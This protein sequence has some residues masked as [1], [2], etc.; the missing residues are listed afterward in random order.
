MEVSGAAQAA[1][2]IST[3]SGEDGDF[4]CC[5][6]EGI[7]NVG[8]QVSSRIFHHLENAKLE[9]LDSDSIDF[10][11]FVFCNGWNFY[12]VLSEESCSHLA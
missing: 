2:A 3:R 9:I 11:H 10:S 12:S 8:S 5:P 1:T 4:S 7:N 6:T